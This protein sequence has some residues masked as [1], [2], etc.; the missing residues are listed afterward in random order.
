MLIILIT[1]CSALS[2]ETEY[3]NIKPTI[4]IL[5]F[6]GKIGEKVAVQGSGFEPGEKVKIILQVGNVPLQWAEVETG[7]VAIADEKGDFKIIPAGGIPVAAL[8]VETGLFVVRASGDKG[9]KAIAPIV[10]LE[11]K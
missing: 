8:F 3:T 9:S 4:R 6:I 10:I 2:A 5:P 1:C 11:K 7:G